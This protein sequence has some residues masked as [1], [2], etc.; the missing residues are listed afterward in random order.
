MILKLL[1]PYNVG[2]VWQNVALKASSIATCETS[3]ISGWSHFFPDSMLYWVNVWPMVIRKLI[4][5]GS[6]EGEN[7][8]L[9]LGKTVKVPV[10]L[11]A[12][13]DTGLG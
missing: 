13:K 6:G 3:N 1:T 7:G 8:Y 12:E 11:L 2:H 9:S 4:I 10:I 5:E